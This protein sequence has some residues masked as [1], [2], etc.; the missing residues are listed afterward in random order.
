[1]RLDAPA[2]G[3]GALIER[4]ARRVGQASLSD[5]FR[6]V[7]GI[8]DDTAALQIGEQTLL[9]TADMLLEDSTR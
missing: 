3:E 8:G 4:I 9:W 2:E 1:M 6:L 7:L 5:A